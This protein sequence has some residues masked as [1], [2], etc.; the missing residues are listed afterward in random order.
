LAT[1]RFAAACLQRIRVDLSAFHMIFKGFV[2]QP[3]K[4]TR[5]L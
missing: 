3:R 1:E 2:S 5:H 4:K